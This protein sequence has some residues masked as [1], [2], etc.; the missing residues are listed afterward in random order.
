MRKQFGLALYQLLIFVA[1]SSLMGSALFGMKEAHSTRV[2][3]PFINSAVIDLQVATFEYYSLVSST[4]NNDPLR[5]VC[6]NFTVN[7][8]DLNSAGLI[9]QWKLDKALKVNFSVEFIR[10]PTSSPRQRILGS[11]VIVTFENSSDATDYSSMYLVNGQT[12]NAINID[13][14]FTQRGT[15]NFLGRLSRNSNSG[16]YEEGEAL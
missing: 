13:Q 12:L 7:I 3:M 2:D 6:D 10:S 5:T 11:R 4:L 8:S 14:L 16:C 15:K 1:L 9:E